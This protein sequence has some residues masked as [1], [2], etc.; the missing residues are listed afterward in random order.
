MDFI[1]AMR[2]FGPLRVFANK[3][4][5]FYLLENWIKEEGKLPRKK[6]RCTHYVKAGRNEKEVHTYYHNPDFFHTGE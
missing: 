4:G 1:E 2:L 5:E 3:Y 6:K